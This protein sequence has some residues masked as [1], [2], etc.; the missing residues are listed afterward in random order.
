[1]VT[2][3]MLKNTVGRVLKTCTCKVLVPVILPGLG[4]HRG[5][6]V[7]IPQVEGTPGKCRWGRQTALL[8]MAGGALAAPRKCG[9][10]R[11]QLTL[12]I[13]EVRLGQCTVVS[14]ARNNNAFDVSPRKCRRSRL[15]ELRW[16]SAVVDRISW[17]ATFAHLAT[18]RTAYSRRGNRH[19]VLNNL[20]FW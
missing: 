13:V 19:L 10:C 3:Q 7:M 11:R 17:Y 14:C 12:M 6:D 2:T 5:S 16:R 1:M 4:S 15:M 8:L 18:G 9:G 20:E